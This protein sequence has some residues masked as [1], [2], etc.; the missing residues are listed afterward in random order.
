MN[1][2]N[3]LLYN[4]TQFVCGPGVRF[5]DLRLLV[6]FIWALVGLIIG[7]MIHVSHRAFFR[8]LAVV[9][10]RRALPV[11]WVVCSGGSDTV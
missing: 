6:T 9:Y 5:P 4:L 2:H 8:R 1:N 10:R 7:E 3:T 11:G